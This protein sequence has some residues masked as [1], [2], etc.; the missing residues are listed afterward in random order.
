VLARDGEKLSKRHG[1]V[2]ADSTREGGALIWKALSFLGQAVPIELQ[3]ATPRE[4]LTWGVMH[5]SLDR[6]SL[7]PALAEL[8]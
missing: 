5:F 3:A 2:V 7:Q 8:N 6:V 4:I 1:A